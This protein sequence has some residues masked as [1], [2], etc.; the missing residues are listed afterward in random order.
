MPALSQGDVASLRS[1]VGAKRASRLTGDDAYPAHQGGRCISA[2]M[3][4]A[5]Y[6]HDRWG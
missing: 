2:P 4:V 6:C 3:L 5:E 1:S